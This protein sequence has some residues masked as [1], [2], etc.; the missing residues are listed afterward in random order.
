M[1]R[2]ELRRIED[3][4]IASNRWQLVAPLLLLASEEVTRRSGLRRHF[5][6]RRVPIVE[7]GLV[8]DGAAGGPLDL[9]KFELLTEI[10]KSL[11]FFFL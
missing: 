1:E 3:L 8:E 9:W 7:Q 6:E 11:P 5:P 10:R 4:R 2:C